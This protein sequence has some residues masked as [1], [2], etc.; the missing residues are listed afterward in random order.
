[1]KKR[2][3]ERQRAVLADLQTG[4]TWRPRSNLFGEGFADS[5]GS[6]LPKRT[7]RALIDRRF[8]VMQRPN[9]LALTQAG[10]AA[11][12]ESAKAAPAPARRTPESPKPKAR[13]ERTERNLATLI[14]RAQAAAR[15]FLAELDVAL[16][17]D[18]RAVVI[19]GTRTYEEQDALY[20]KGRTTPGPKVTNAR[21]G[22]S[23]HNFGIAF[24]IGLFRGRE[25]LTAS[26]LYDQCGPIGEKHGLEWGGRWKSFPDTPHYQLALGLSVAEMRRR[27]A[28][29][30]V[31]A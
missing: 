7:V 8:V 26:P 10:I 14:P 12:L 22:Y 23:N 11:L 6:T 30:E 16:P 18:V 28:A 19:S 24:D 4:G 20:A 5:K 1:M 29:G 27:V 15:A 3:T 21:G 31:I 9:K 13:D 17:P 25:Y 2:L